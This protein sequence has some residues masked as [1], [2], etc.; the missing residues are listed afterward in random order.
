MDMSDANAAIAES[1]GKVAGLVVL[2]IV[3]AI[4]TA[5]AGGSGGWAFLAAA[6]G[7]GATM[8][9]GEALIFNKSM[10]AEEMAVSWAVNTA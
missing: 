6:A 2:G 8:T 9:A 3:A 5:P 1:V 7:A 4:A 10:N